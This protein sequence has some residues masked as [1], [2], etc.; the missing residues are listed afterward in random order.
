MDLISVIVPIYNVERYLEKCIN[1]ITKQTYKNLEIILVNDGSTDNSLNICQKIEKS[2]KRIKIINKKNEGVSI[3]RNEG[4]KIANGK[5]V[6]FIDSDDYIQNDMIQYLYEIILKGVDIAICD[7][8]I[9]DEKNN[10]KIRNYNCTNKI[11]ILEQKEALI[12]LLKDK[13]IHNYAWAKLYKMELF[14]NIKYPVGRK[15]EDLG[16][17][18]KLFL[19]AVKIGYGTEKKYFYIQREESIMHTISEE[20]Y[21]DLYELSFERFKTIK[22]RYPFLLENDINMILRILGIYRKCNIFDYKYI[23][24]SKMEEIYEKILKG[25]TLKIFFKVDAKYKIKM[26]LFRIN[27]NIYRNM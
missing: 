25:K 12:R 3:A 22:K 11:S 26:I 21:K 2:D 17:M 9:L 15:M 20:F 14:K 16:I 5:Y 27:R 8:I 10:R 23:R 4:W 1:S 6:T 18:Y 24:D 7:Y 13:E 19:E